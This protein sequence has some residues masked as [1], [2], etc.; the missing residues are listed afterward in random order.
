[1][2]ADVGDR[3]VVASGTRTGRFETARSCRRDQMAAGRTWCD[4][5]IVATRAC[6]PRSGRACRACPAGYRRRWRSAGSSRLAHRADQEMAGRD[7]PV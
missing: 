5:L 1:M 2:K 4:G 3:I 7:L 6:F